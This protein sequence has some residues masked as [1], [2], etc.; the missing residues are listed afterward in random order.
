MKKQSDF[1]L[2]EAI[3]YT[4]GICLLTFYSRWVGIP[5]VSVFLFFVC[6][7][8]LKVVSLKSPDK[9]YHFL[10]IALLFLLGIAV[11]KFFKEFTQL[12]PYFIPVAAFSMLVSA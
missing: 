3:L 11:V 10:Q 9:E 1:A 6:A 12:S 2:K 7:A 8:Y 5:L 4:A